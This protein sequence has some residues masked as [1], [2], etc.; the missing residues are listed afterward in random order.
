[1]AAMINDVSLAALVPSP[2]NPRKS[3]GDLK[4]LTASIK[5]DGV[6]QPILVRPIAGDK[7]EIVYGHRRAQAARLAG[8]GE[9]LAE[10]REI[11]D[12]DVRSIQLVENVQRSDLHPMEEA[13]TYKALID[14]RKISVEEVA[15]Q[16]GKSTA[17]VRQRLKLLTLCM[18]ARVAF[19]DGKLSAAAAFLIA[20][21]PDHASQ[22]KVLSEATGWSSE[23]KVV[24]RLAESAAQLYMQDL[25]RAPFDPKDG[26]L[27]RAGACTACPKRTGNAPELFPDV[28]KGDVCTDPG[29]WSTKAKAFTD[30]KIAEAR[31]EGRKVLS[32]KEA[33]E[34]FHEHDRDGGR[35]QDGKWRGLHEYWEGLPYDSKNREVPL[36]TL[37]KHCGEQGKAVIDGAVLAVDRK[38]VV[39]ELV[40]KAAALAALKKGRIVRPKTSGSDGDALPGAER[41]RR[42]DRLLREQVGFRALGEIATAIEKRPPNAGIL[43]LVICLFRENIYLDPKVEK[44]MP[45]A[46]TRVT[47][48]VSELSATLA[49]LAINDNFTQ[50]NAFSAELKGL[51]ALCRVDLKKIEKFVVAEREAEAKRAVVG[52]ASPAT[53]KPGGGPKLKATTK[54]AAATAHRL[55]R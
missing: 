25:S 28:K 34:V 37:L 53:P 2:T 21:L 50:G 51:A 30:R 27:T 7:F 11:K 49:T 9:I 19:A 13:E 1:M 48:T 46:F 55:A 54:A 8:L 24:E 36:K 41:K 23:G 5:A 38:G 32:A 44:R 14:H 4:D 33:A 39:R 52:K 6:Q 47:G 17:T 12:E 43:Q 26:S 3:L 22:R 29:C 31:K 42:D 10:V 16:V 18:E 35:T 40:S 15:A 20:R 45:K